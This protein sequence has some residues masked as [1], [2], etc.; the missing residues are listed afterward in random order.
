MAIRVLKAYRPLFWL[1]VMLA[2]IAVATVVLHALI[3][4][5]HAYVDP[6]AQLDLGVLLRMPIPVANKIDN[7]WS[8]LAVVWLML[9]VLSYG[10]YRYAQALDANSA[11]PIILGFLVVCAA[12][13]LFPILLSGD[14]YAYII[15]GRLFGL[16]GVNPY[17]LPLPIKPHFDSAIDQC[18][19][20]YGNPPPGDNYGPLW[21]L[22]AGG[23]SAL[24]ATTSLTFQIIVQRALAVGFAILAVAGL[25]RIMRRREHWGEGIARY[26]F[27]PV[28]LFET[29]VGA[30]NDIMMVALATWAFA[31]VEEMPLLAGLLM[32]ASIATKYLS[33]C[34]LP[35]LV[36]KAGRKG[37]Q[38]ALALLTVALAIPIITFRPFWMGKLTAQSLIWQSANVSMSPSWIA[39]SI[40]GQVGHE[41]FVQIALTLAFV[42]LYGVALRRYARKLEVSN[43][44]LVIAALLWI[45]PM[46]NPWYTLWLLPAAAASGYWARFAWWFGALS[47]LRYSGEVPIY[48]PVWLLIFITLVIFAAPLLLA[49]LRSLGESGSV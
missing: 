4:Q 49:R 10:G 43:L 13:V 6:S 18:L 15:Y 42:A 38:P 48:P 33:L 11:R 9:A 46:L 36:V 12:L 2:T 28:L 24:I 34:A 44:W 29:A 19:T 14:A 47:L 3:L 5:A 30:H 26:A 23:L 1:I 8:I 16:H 39:A 35:F 7:G 21:T 20:I 37:W 45:A 41:R 25:S 40:V 17:Y 22:L 27:H 31:L 32:G